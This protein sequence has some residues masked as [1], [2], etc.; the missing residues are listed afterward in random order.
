M[1]STKCKKEK[2]EVKE[3]RRCTQCKCTMLLKYFS[4]NRQGDHFK[5]CDG[6]RQKAKERRTCVH[7]KQKTD[8]AP[9]GGACEHGRRKNQCPRCAGVEMCESHNMTLAGCRSVGKCYA[10]EKYRK[11]MLERGVEH[12]DNHELPYPL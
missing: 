4:M 6:C 3:L 10:N 1:K 7:G 11:L 8:C 2:K 5:S 12:L 9:C